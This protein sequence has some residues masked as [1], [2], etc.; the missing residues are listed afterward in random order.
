MI[1][2][3]GAIIEKADLPSADIAR[4]TMYGDAV[5]ETLKMQE[6]KLFFIEDHY[7]RL[8]AGMRILRMPISMDFTPEFF[9][10]QAE[11][12]A[13]EVAIENGRLRI[14]VVRVADGKYTPSEDQSTVWWMEL[15]ELESIEYIHAEKGLTVD[16]F[17]DHYIQPGLLSTIKSSNSLPYVLGGIYARENNLDAVLMVNDNKMLVEANASNVFVLKGDVLRTAPLE[18]GAL[19]GV[20]RKNLLNWGKE[21]GLQVKEESINPF[22]LQK[23]DEIWLTNTITGVQWVEKYRKNT[24]K[25]DKAKEL[26]ELLERKLNV[27]GAL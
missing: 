17:K 4:A 11:R 22:D 2:Y 26:V 21:I 8:M 19:R 6:G 24:Y 12:L 5:F 25:G 23:A 15:E 3:N 14:Q 7:F 1:N 18:D 10:E 20:F 27:L 16:L 9:I 13:E